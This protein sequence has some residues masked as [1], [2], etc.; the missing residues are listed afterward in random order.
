MKE[1]VREGLHNEQE[2]YQ[3]LLEVVRMRLE[4]YCRTAVSLDENGALAGIKG[5]LIFKKEL[6]KL[7]KAPFSVE[8]AEE[9]RI[10]MLQIQEREQEL[11]RLGTAYMEQGGMSAMEYLCR[12]F[13]LNNMEYYLLSMALAAELDGQFER[14]FCL[15]QD[16]YSL[17]LPTL[18][19][20]VR[21]LTL[22][23]GER[24][25]FQQRIMERLDVL[26]LFFDGIQEILSDRMQGEKRSCLSVPLKINGRLLLFLQ[27]ITSDDEILKD[28]T[29]TFLPGEASDEM[30]IRMEYADRLERLIHST[31]GRRFLFLSGSRDIGKKTLVRHLC[32]KMK[33]TLLMVHTDRLLSGDDVEGKVK[34]LVRESF[35]K[36]HAW[37][38]F[39]DAELS[40]EA[41]EPDR[42]MEKLLW[43]LRDYQ[44][45][46][47]FTSQ[48]PWNNIPEPAGRSCLK[49]C[50]PDTDASE[51]KTLWKRLLPDGEW[52]A[53]ITPDRIADKYILTPGG[54]KK[55]VEAARQRCCMEGKRRM[56]AEMLFSACQKQLIHK[57]GKD[58]LKVESPYVWDDLILP[59]PQKKLLRDACDQV[60]Y[61][62]KV[63]HDWGF[64][65]KVAYGRGVSMIFYGPPGTGKTMGAQVM[66]NELGLE[67]YKINMAGIMS[68][69]VGES[70]KKLDVVFEQ[71]KRSQSILFFDEADVLFGKRSETK[72][73]QDKYA[74]ASTAYLLQKVEE[75]EGILILATNFLQNFDNAFC[76]R[77]KFIIEF[78]F[79]DAERR[80]AIWNHVFPGSLEWSEG[81]DLEW[82]AEEFQFSGSQIKNIALSASFLAAGEGSGLTMRHVLTALKREQLK[83]G[84]QMIASD[85]GQYYYLMV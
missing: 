43:A 44:G 11:R 30:L 29:E 42:N 69:Y 18:D 24:L 41:D 59:V 8:E 56:T 74:N 51:R 71:G 84:K 76:R 14:I 53:D 13:H 58:A 75:Y 23:E 33:K 34:R 39:A 47:V 67:L 25:A 80:L 9:Y 7:T 62:Q 70:E 32:R 57:L 54:I 28:F 52:P 46:P 12:I 27:D 77:F 37:I 5:K 45:I 83:V 26:S 22:D 85:F 35:L 68:R 66:A 81:I 1:L 15:L 50:L 60:E 36:G 6:E 63:Y 19:L 72:D 48:R 16:D 20:C 4:L 82:L 55:S 49:F 38:C 21:I 40:E 2:Y 17:K 73:A 64:A 61:Q 10:Q 79:P 3:I 31:S 65:Q 78:P